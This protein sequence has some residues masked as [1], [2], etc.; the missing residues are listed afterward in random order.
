MTVTGSE[1]TDVTSP[2]AK[3]AVNTRVWAI[4]GVAT[5]FSSEKVALPPEIT[6]SLKGLGVALESRSV[7]A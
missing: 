5:I 7:T 4:P 1:S 6:A 3:L 2:V